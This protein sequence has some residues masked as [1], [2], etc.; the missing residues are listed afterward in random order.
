MLNLTDPNP[1][2]Q[3]FWLCPPTDKNLKLYVDWVKQEKKDFFP[4]EAEGCCRI[5][6]FPGNTVFLPA[7]WIHAV[8]T[9]K[10]SIAFSGSFLHSFSILNQLKVNY[11]EDSL[12]RIIILQ[13]KV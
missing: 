2:F 10:D 8:F 7:G 3:V 12:G 11:I 1:W 5:E 9:I 4:E 13:N 6:V